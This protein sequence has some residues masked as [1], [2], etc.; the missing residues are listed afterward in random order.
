MSGGHTCGIVTSGH[1]PPVVALT[2]FR[3]RALPDKLLASP[4]VHSIELL[5]SFCTTSAKRMPLGARSL[6]RR[7]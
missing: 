4:A 6:W 5:R 7:T 1:F 3:F 2:L